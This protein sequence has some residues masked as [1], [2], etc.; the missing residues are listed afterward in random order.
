MTTDSGR[1]RPTLTRVGVASWSVIGAL[2]LAS[3]VVGV[4][5]AIS[6][7]VL[8]LIFAVMIGA[9]AYPLAVR[10]QRRVKP[11]VAALVVVVGAIGVVV[12][13]VLITISAIVNE[14]GTLSGHV[15]DA[16]VELGSTTDSVGLD[17]AELDAIRDAVQSVAAII[18]RGVMTLLVGGLGALVAFIGGGILGMLIMYYVLKD[19]PQIRNWVVAQ[20]PEH[21]RAEATSFVS[22]AVRTVRA[23]WAGRTVLSAIITTVIVLVSLILGLPMIGAIAVA[24]FVGGYVPYIGAFIGGGLA[25]LMALADGGMGEALLVLAIVLACNLLLENVMEPKVMSGRLSVHPLAVLLATTTGGVVGGIIGLVLAVPV[26]VVSVDL[27][28]RLRSHG[29]VN[30]ARAK[31]TTLVT[32]RS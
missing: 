23:Y 22:D 32:D 2:V 24:N 7:L 21:L 11:S 9:T 4:L 25:V 14:M 1:G 16:M 5:A 13:V 31:A 26:M 18:G 8:P 17:A 10:L 27:V 12:G 20:A 3:M 15:D 30:A 28:R 29:V 19:G 6:E